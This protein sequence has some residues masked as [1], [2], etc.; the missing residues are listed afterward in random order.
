[1]DTHSFS[2]TNILLDLLLIKFTIKMNYNSS[3]V[4]GCK[5]EPLLIYRSLPVCIIQYIL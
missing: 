2:Q 5:F 1:M 3:E 4:A